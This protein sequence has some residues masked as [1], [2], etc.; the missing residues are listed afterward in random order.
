V[1][2]QGSLAPEIGLM[3][4]L[5][6][7][8]PNR[9]AVD[10]GANVGKVARGLLDAG[11][12]VYA[13]EPYPPVFQALSERLGAEPGFHGFPVALGPADDTRPLY[14]ASDTSATN[15]Y[16]DPTLY[17]SLIRH[18]M[19]EDLAFTDAVPVTVRSLE[20]VHASGDIPASVGLVKIDTEGFDLAVI[21]GMG[22]HQYDV[23]VAE[24]WDPGIP[25]AA[26]GAMNRLDELVAEM[27]RRGYHW[28]VIFHTTWGDEDVGFYCNYSHSLTRAWGN[29]FFFRDHQLFT[30]ALVWCA[31]VLPGTYVCG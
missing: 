22:A 7:Y 13:F 31:A 8:L 2:G 29:V 15:L 14:V 5:Y 1:G 16:G 17:S 10:V 24:Y 3:A 4:Y 30:H 18:A 26:T 9:T 20:S 25:F 19:P 21:R 27:R 6:S 28:N 11:Y 23:V 12:E